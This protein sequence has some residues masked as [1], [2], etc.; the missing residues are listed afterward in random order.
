MRYP[1]GKGT[2]FQKLIN[3]MPPHQVYIE[4]HLGG[5]SVMRHK[6]PASSNI[7]IE[8]DPRIIALWENNQ[9]LSFKLVNDDAT[10]F[11]KSYNFTGKELLYCDPPYLQSTR[12]S[13]GRKMYTYD[14]SVHD[15]IILLQLLR[16]LP[17]MVMISGYESDLY[18]EMLKDWHTHTFEY[19]CHNGMGIEWLWMNYPTPT[20]LHDYRYLGHNFRERERIKKKT[21]R[22][23]SNL[24]NMPVLERHAL[25]NAMNTMKELGCYYGN[26]TAKSGVKTH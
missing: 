23:L 10:N 9:P 8:K 3:L 14:Y 21:E 15:H 11:L 12:K 4:T 1:G 13:R 26:D 25:L 2:C 20:E 19:V 7:G 24:K 6:R 17:C 5:G 16:S 18:K 22:W